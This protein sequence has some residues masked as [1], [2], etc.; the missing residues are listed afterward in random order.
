MTVGLEDTHMQAKVDTRG[1]DYSGYASNYDAA[2]FVGRTNEYLE[3][4]RLNALRA[5]TADL[6]RTERV[7]DVGCGTGRGLANLHRLGFSRTTGLDFTHDMLVQSRPKLAAFDGARAALVRGSAFALPF[8][9]DSLAAVTSFNFVHMFRFELQR[10]IIDEMRRICRPGGHLVVE[11]ESVHKGL[12]FNRYL[13]QRRFRE[14][15]KFN[16][17]WEVR[18]LFPES[19]FASP[20]V[21]GSVF[22]K[23]YTILRHV[24]AAGD[25]VESLAHH[26]PL[27]WL[28]ERVLVR[29][30]VR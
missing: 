24:P 6:S 27:N 22:P 9:T 28:A 23:I 8:A 11:F 2:R 19:R 30:T 29:A 16:S 7:L 15:T 14:R 26:P 10:E 17:I 25:R 5:A 18:R 12:F 20:R 21:V 4:V 3:R 1:I 13:E